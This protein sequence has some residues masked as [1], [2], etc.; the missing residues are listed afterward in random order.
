MRHAA[1]WRD[2]GCPQIERQRLTSEFLGDYNYAVAT[3]E[4]SAAVW[5]DTRAA[6]V[7]PAINAFQQ[8]LV[9]G[10][11][12]LGAGTQPGLPRCGRLLR[13]Q[14]HLRRHLRRAHDTLTI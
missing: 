14:R 11:P 1:P 9:D 6:A 7:C 3:R 12:R 4:F 13:Q 5:D 2:R 8:S 10:N